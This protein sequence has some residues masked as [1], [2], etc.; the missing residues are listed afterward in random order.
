MIVR[1]LSTLLPLIF[2]GCG[3]SAVPVVKVTGNAEVKKPGKNWRNLQVR[4]G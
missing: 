2:C 1:F 3:D 4:D